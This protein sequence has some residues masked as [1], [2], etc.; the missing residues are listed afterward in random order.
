MISMNVKYIS[1]ISVLS[2]LFGWDFLII[3]FPYFWPHLASLWLFPQQKV[4]ILKPLLHPSRNISQL[5]HIVCL[6]D[7]CTTTGAKLA[8]LILQSSLFILG[9][10]A[11]S[12]QILSTFPE[13]VLTGTPS[14]DISKAGRLTSCE[15][16]DSQPQQDSKHWKLKQTP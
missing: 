12:L 6:T 4:E 2:V 8:T 1:H 3:C 11:F 10:L 13:D 5:P 7:R 9:K 14:A 16:C 15:R